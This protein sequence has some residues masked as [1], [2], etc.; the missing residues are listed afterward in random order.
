MEENKNYS[1]LPEEKDSI[2]NGETAADAAADE[3]SAVESVAETEA[4]TEAAPEEAAEE[5][6]AV[7]EAP[8]A[9]E[10]SFGG[11]A[12]VA[13]R[14]SN[15]R[16][17]RT[18]IILFA[19]VFAVCILLLG[20]SF[21]LGD[22]GIRLIRTLHTERTVF[23]RE[24]T[25]EGGLLSA[26]E[27][28]DLI[29][30]STVTVSVRTSAGGSGHGSGFLYR[31]ED[32]YTYICTNNHV[33]SGMS[34]VQVILADGTVYDATVV[35]TDADADVAV[36]KIAKTGLPLVTVGSSAN[37]LTGEDVFAVGTPANIAYAGTVTF[38]KVSCPSRL[39]PMTDTSGSVAYK[40]TLIQTDA[41]LNNGNSG[42]PLADMYGKVVGMVVL[43]LAIYNGDDVDGIAFALPIDG[44]KIIADEI[45]QKGSFSGTNPITEGASALGVTGHAV[46]EG[47]WYSLD[48]ASNRVQ[49]SATQA[50]GYYYAEVSGV[51][52]SVI[53]SGYAGDKLFA[54]DIILKVNGLSVRDITELIQAVNRH[55]IG[56]TVTLTVWRDGAVETVNV[57]LSE[58]PAS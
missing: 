27:A 20:L 10:W 35:G 26:E 42:G 32:G 45:I 8:V 57:M 37:L 28:A 16:G 21:F 7:D 13:A 24:Y 1:E 29:K 23:V 53:G 48:T 11:E 54:G 17:T 44:V 47:Y 15:K 19:A 38:G 36:V 58:K 30:K 18:F 9:P 40:M 25:G 56:E 43:K 33:V 41:A 49:E 31:E 34:E 55:Y 2:E 5:E 50:D 52:V 12:D 39:L 3:N 22:G 6:P 14:A 46:R 4:A 51:Y